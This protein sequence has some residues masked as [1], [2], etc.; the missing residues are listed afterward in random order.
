[1]SKEPLP[2]WRTFSKMVNHFC[3]KAQTFVYFVPCDFVQISTTCGSNTYQIMY[4]KTLDFQCQRQC[5]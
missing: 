3:Q 4:G 2:K 1:M 5:Q